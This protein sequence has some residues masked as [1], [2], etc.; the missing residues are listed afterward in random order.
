MNGDQSAVG[1][2]QDVRLSETRPIAGGGRLT[3]CE[4]CSKRFDCEVRHRFEHGHFDQSAALGATAFEQGAEYT[5]RRVDAG[6]RIRKR[7]PRKRGR[8]GST[9]TLRKPLNACATES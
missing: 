7:G 4:E 2:P 5:V 9:T 1:R 3:E 8:S 6:D